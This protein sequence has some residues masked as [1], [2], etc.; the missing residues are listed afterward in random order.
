MSLL[1]KELIEKIAG[2]AEMYA[3]GADYFKSGRVKNILQ[4]GDMVKAEVTGTM[5]QPYKVKVIFDGENIRYFC[6]C[7]YGGACKHIIAVLLALENSEDG[8][9]EKFIDWKEKLSLLSKEEL[10]EILIPFLHSD[11]DLKLTLLKQMADKGKDTSVEEYYEHWDEAKS[12]LEEFQTYG[13]GSEEDEETI[14][15]N[16]EEITK[17]F[18]EEKLPSDIKE[19]FINGVLDY[20]L[21]GNT[22]LDDF[23]ID[24]AFEVAKDKEDWLHIIKRLREK[25]GSW[26]RKLIM[27]IYRNHL[28]DKEKYLEERMKELEYG[29]DYYDLA[30]FYKENG[31]E[32]KAV[33][34]AQEGVV[35]GKGRK[36]D[37]YELIFEYC[38][39]RDYEKAL[40]YL[41][42]IFQEKMSLDNYKRLIVFSR[43][44]E[45]E[46]DWALSLLKKEKEWGV[47]AQ[48][49]LYEGRYENVLKY[50]MDESRDSF[51][52]SKES[53]AEEIKDRYPVEIISFYKEKVISFTK[54]ENR[55]SYQKAVFYLRRIKQIYVE[56]LKDKVSFQKYIQKLTQQYANRPAFLD[57]VKS[58]WNK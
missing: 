58:L 28:N 21:G 55:R 12:L 19:E 45:M 13:G 7:P 30:N 35:R 26:E 2:S 40:K 39:E 32:E 41:R 14:Y 5:P 47:L 49:D 3:K 36:I 11:K 8:L 23:L 44:K 16:L 51:F 22:G 4:V 18:R 6:S 10:I 24:F 1:T 52:C 50:I 48:I 42:K 29:M 15:Y 25:D 33:E 27:D 9:D 46:S 43:E 57:E 37:L 56:I 20:Y 17:L 31:E 38:K 53:F 34:I 54:Q